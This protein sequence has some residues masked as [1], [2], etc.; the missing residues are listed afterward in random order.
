MKC[1]NSFDDLIR[2][3][4]RGV[5][6]NIDVPEDMF[7]NIK[8]NIK[9]NEKGAIG[10]KKK[11]FFV[12]GIVI[13][14]VLCAATVGTIA[15][16][17]VASWSGHSSNLTETKE[18]PDISEVKDR[19]GIEPKYT[20]ELPGGFKFKHFNTSEGKGMD[21]DGNTVIE[22]TSANFNYERENGNEGEILS[23]DVEALPKE[24][25]DNQIKGDESDKAYRKD[26]THAGID[27]Q[28]SEMPYKFVPPDYKLTDE[29]QKL[30][31]EHKIEISYGSQEIEE[32]L[33][34]SV[35]WYED[36]MKYLILAMDANLSEDV[37]V[38]MAETVIDAE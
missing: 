21:V 11:S 28:Y 23:L 6:E 22:V 17:N 14:A 25:Y 38:E 12:K 3:H 37:M 10:M 19:A 34:Q 24:I 31:D 30:L 35:C 5:S 33:C 16:T 26:Y 8:N 2:K 15:A 18:F 9:K 13:A 20:Q 36:G 7:Q 4:F 29:D 27:L 1:S 32:M